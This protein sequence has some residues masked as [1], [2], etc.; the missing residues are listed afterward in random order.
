[1]PTILH[2]GAMLHYEARG[3]G[4]TVVLHHALVA[5]SRSWDMIGV[6][7]G[8]AEAGFRCVTFDAVG[9]GRSD[10]AT[11]DRLGLAARVGDVLAIADAVGAE[12]FHYVGYS[13]GAWIGTG[14]ARYAPDRLQSLFLAGWD[15][16]DGARRFTRLTETA[17]RNV[18]FGEVI[19]SLAATSRQGPAPDR[20]DGYVT[21]YERL[22]TEL[23]SITYLIDLKCPL[24]MAVGDS[25]PY[26][27]PVGAACESLAVDWLALPGDHITAFFA[28]AFKDSIE[29]W[30]DRLCKS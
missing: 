29:K 3:A 21:T 23:P 5:D 22:F 1:M 15:P 30:L 25:D 6:V 7:D 16:I 17:A 12:R 9:H 28:S 13:M 8:L 20:I 26:F 27:D 4:P 19:R 14:L 11:G 24:M 2:D 10:D 18:E